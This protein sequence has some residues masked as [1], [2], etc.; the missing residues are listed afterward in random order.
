M[1]LLVDKHKRP[2]ICRAP[3]AMKIDITDPSFKLLAQ[4]RGFLQIDNSYFRGGNG[5]WPPA[6]P[7]APVGSEHNT[8]SA[9][10]CLQMHDQRVTSA[11]RTGVELGQR[12][13][14]NR[15]ATAISIHALHGILHRSTPCVHG[16][17]PKLR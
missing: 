9:T 14:N 1:A 4:S 5:L 10:C 15:D 6:A 17:L 7:A 3:L 13:A 8:L 16:D 12:A 11:T 2:P